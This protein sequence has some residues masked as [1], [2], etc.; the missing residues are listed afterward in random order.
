MN[1][2]EVE[3]LYQ[4]IN[5]F[6]AL[7][8]QY[9]L[10]EQSLAQIEM[11]KEILYRVPESKQIQGSMQQVN[12]QLVSAEAYRDAVLRLIKDTTG[13][14]V[15]ELRQVLSELRLALTKYSEL[16]NEF[17]KVKQAF[18]ILVETDGFDPEEGQGGSR[19]EYA[20]ELERLKANKD[21]LISYLRRLV[22][23]CLNKTPLVVPTDSVLGP[24]V[25]Q[26]AKEI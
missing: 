24:L 4:A 1:S 16:Q 17:A 22:L 26:Q 5:R 3:V 11:Q 12:E 20:D 23:N 21:F 18:D 13:K 2:E 14:D 7:S 6:G 10:L 8:E 25:R 9:D 19:K 15:G